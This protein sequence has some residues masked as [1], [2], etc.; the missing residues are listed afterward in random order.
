AGWYS[1]AMACRRRR[2]PFQV[3]VFPYRRAGDGTLEVALF[4]RVQGG[5]WQGIAG[6]G[7]EGEAPEAAARRETAE[8]AGLAPAGRW[9]ALA[10]VLS[11]PVSVIRPAERRHWPGW[12]ST[13]PCHPFAVPVADERITLS[14]E[15]T[16]YCWASLGEAL[17]LVRWDNDRAALAALREA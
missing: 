2:A 7:E 15:H 16:E 17:R 3:L 12:L 8:E 9:L 1:W 11:I 6:G 4:R 13:I 5:Y 10:P 14:P